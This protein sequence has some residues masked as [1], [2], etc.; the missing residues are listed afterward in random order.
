PQGAAVPVSAGRGAALAIPPGARALAI[1]GSVGQPRDGDPAAC[2]AMLD[3]D[4]R[5]IAFHRVPYDVATAAAKIRDAGLP[6][7]LAARL[8][9]G[10]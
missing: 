3:T 2:W 6:E 10:G 1:P 8:E 4:R 5:T 9:R 7:R